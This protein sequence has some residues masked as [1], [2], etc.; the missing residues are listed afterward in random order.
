MPSSDCGDDFVGIG[1]PLEGF[2]LG[3][4]IV[5]KAVDCGLEVGDRPEG[6]AFEAAFG[7]DCEKSLDGVDPGSRGR[8]EVERPAWM[9]RKP[10]PY[11]GMFVRGVVVEDCVD[12]LAGRDLPLDRVEKADELLM[13][14]ALHVAANDGSVE[15]VHRREQGRRPV[16]LVVVGHSSSASFLERQA[17]LCSVER[18]DLA[19]FVDGKHCA[20]GST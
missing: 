9:T 7:Q 12:R 11:G 14:M 16:P 5:E 17:G 19:L 13:P 1:D 10:L 8:G 4:V 2:R 6:P 18:L 15:D 3:V 20:G